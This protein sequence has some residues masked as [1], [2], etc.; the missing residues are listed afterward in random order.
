MLQSH[1]S[2]QQME[3]WELVNFCLPFTSYKSF[4][5]DSLVQELKSLGRTALS[6]ALTLHT[7]SFCRRQSLCLRHNYKYGWYSPPSLR[8]INWT[9]GIRDSKFKIY[10]IQIL[11]TS[12]PFHLKAGALVHAKKQPG[13]EDNY[14]P[15]SGDEDKNEWSYTT[16]AAY[17]FMAWTG[18]ALL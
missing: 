8:R 18:A 6:P 11:P 2:S 5:T 17:D 9:W 12:T 14:S 3:F 1:V 7:C 15:A 4:H 13:R 16:T 10:K